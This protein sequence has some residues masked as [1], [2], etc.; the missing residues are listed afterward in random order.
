MHNKYRLKYFLVVFS[1]AGLLSILT[2]LNIHQSAV[3]A[4]TNHIVWPLYG[5]TFLLE[6]LPN[7]PSSIG[8][9][10]G[11]YRVL[12]MPGDRIAAH[13]RTPVKPYSQIIH[14]AARRHRVDPALIKAVILAESKYNPEAISKKGAK[15]LMQLMPLT[16]KS[17]GV[18]DIFDPEDNINGGTRYLK[19]LLDRFDG[20]IKLALAAYNAGSRY[21]KKY[22]GVPP[23]LQTKTFI[24]KVLK[25]HR[26][27][28]K[29]DV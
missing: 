15:G 23:F 7:N 1:I 14:A 2:F 3:L 22:G 19:K 27:Y 12:N 6:N 20:D 11:K 5:A 26:E 16:A 29:V 18:A 10:I 25:Y 9:P 28:R 8:F 13:I 24:K 4:K 21:V 17:L